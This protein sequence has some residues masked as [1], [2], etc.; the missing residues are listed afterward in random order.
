[1]MLK[2]GGVYKLIY[3]W[4]TITGRHMQPDE[5]FIVL[6]IKLMPQKLNGDQAAVEIL[7]T[8]LIQTK[9]TMLTKH[10]KYFLQE[11]K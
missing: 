8:D 9:F 2:P 5:R 7:T 11:L 10:F 1:M 4:V 6:A 3:N